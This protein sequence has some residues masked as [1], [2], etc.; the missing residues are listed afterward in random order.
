MRDTERLLISLAKEILL[1]QGG[2]TPDRM[3]G[4]A[5]AYY[6]ALDRSAEEAG[7]DGIGTQLVYLSQ[8]L[9]IRNEK[10]RL[11]RD[12]ILNIGL[13]VQSM[14]GMG[15]RENVSTKEVSDTKLSGQTQLGAGGK[16][17]GNASL[18]NWSKPK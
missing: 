18:K 16:M 3:G 13:G 14:L 17:K 8:R 4:A 6:E 7:L 11:A 15:K 5:K 12:T 9:I 10:E 1:G 2:F